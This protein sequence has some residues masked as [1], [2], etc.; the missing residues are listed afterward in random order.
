[1]ADEKQEEKQEA[2]ET[3]EVKETKKEEAPAGSSP[4]ASGNLKVS[5][6][7]LAEIEKALKTVKEKMGGYHSQYGQ[8]LLLRKKELSGSIL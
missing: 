5:Q 1:M 6:M 7:T 4:Q 3:K 8:Q 2:K